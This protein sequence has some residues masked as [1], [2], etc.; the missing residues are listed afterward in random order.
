MN[1]K[2][3]IASATTNETNAN[4]ATATNA[5]ETTATKVDETTT[6]NANEATTTNACDATAT[7]VDEATATNVNEET[8]ATN[9]DETTTTTNANVTTNETTSETATNATKDK[10]SW[11]LLRKRWKLTKIINVFTN[12]MIFVA[13]VQQNVIMMNDFEKKV[14]NEWSFYESQYVDTKK[15]RTSRERRIRWRL[16][17]SRSRFSIFFAFVSWRSRT[18]AASIKIDS[19]TKRQRWDLREVDS[20]NS[21]ACRAKRTRRFF[22]NSSW[23]RDFWKIFASIVITTLKKRNVIWKMIRKKFVFCVLRH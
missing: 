9:V 21:I 10:K 13:I 14:V 22:E 8:T 2:F 15:N 4:R 12:V 5:N 1:T 19:S 16:F 11:I 6:T 20:R 3:A 23:C 17:E 18:I 7:N